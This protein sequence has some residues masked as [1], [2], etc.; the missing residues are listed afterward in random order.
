MV[1]IEAT[2]HKMS[3]EIQQDS[4]GFSPWLIYL[5]MFI[6][7]ILCSGIAFGAY[8]A[9]KTIK[10]IGKPKSLSIKTTETEIY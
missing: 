10:N 6:M 8:F 4:P 1:I 7:M 2:T 5:G 9:H 3:L